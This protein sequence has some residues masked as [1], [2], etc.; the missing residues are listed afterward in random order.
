MNA[1]TE[2]GR[3]S[4]NGTQRVVDREGLEELDTPDPGGLSAE[5][6]PL[7]RGK[8]AR[9]SSRSNNER[10]ANTDSQVP[11]HLAAWHATGSVPASLVSR[12]NQ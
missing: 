2:V 11:R 9:I 4:A 1:R 3:S 10:P 6:P 5:P 7:A 8:C 12:E